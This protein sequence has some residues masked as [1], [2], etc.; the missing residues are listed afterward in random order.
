VKTVDMNKTGDQ[1][2]F[3]TKFGLTGVSPPSFG[4]ACPTYS[5]LLISF[6]PLSECDTANHEMVQF[7]AHFTPALKLGMKQGL[8]VGTRAQRQ[9]DFV[10]NL[11]IVS[12]SHV[13]LCL[14]LDTKVR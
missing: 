6:I 5:L 12:C 2:S 11:I 10:D 9:S 8:E 3:L 13:C 1:I 14:F 7:F 4:F